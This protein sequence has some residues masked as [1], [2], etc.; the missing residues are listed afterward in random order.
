MITVRG[1]FHLN[2]WRNLWCPVPK[3]NVEPHVPK[4][5]QKIFKFFCIFWTCSLSLSVNSVLIFYLLM[6]S[7][8]HRRYS[9]VSWTLTDAQGPFSLLNLQNTCASPNPPCIQSTPPL[10]GRGCER[11][12]RLLGGGEEQV[13]KNMFQGGRE[14]GGHV[15]RG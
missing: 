15:C 5:G 11:P 2:Q 3:L 10:W 1:I 9:R 14:V 7:F 13:V 8:G 12:Q 4:A 6:G